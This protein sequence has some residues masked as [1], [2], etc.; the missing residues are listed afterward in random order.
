MAPWEHATVTLGDI[1]GGKEPTYVVTVVTPQST[2]LPVTA[3]VPVPADATV[4]WAGEVFGGDAR[5]DVPASSVTTSVAG[6]IQYVEFPVSKSRTVQV[7]CTVPQ[8]MLSANGGV[9]AVDMSWAGADVSKEA[10]IAVLAPAGYD[11]T[12]LPQ[13]V[14]MSTMSAGAVFYRQYPKVEAAEGMALRVDLSPAKPATET[15]A[16]TAPQQPQEPASSGTGVPVVVWVAAGLVVVA[17][18]ALWALTRR[19]SR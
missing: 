19:G 10:E 5:Q 11:T 15:A 6:A 4:V 1:A 16:A 7:E 2:K 3:K 17:A 18:I 8:G 13:G 9:L 14:K 12:E